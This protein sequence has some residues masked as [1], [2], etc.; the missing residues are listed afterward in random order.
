MP[1]QDRILPPRPPEI[2]RYRALLRTLVDDH[3]EEIADKHGPEAIPADLLELL[4]AL[5]QDPDL[6][7]EP[8]REPDQGDYCFWPDEGD[9][10]WK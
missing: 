2:D 9:Q 8:D 10:R 3:L 7:Q 6:E 4:N 5:D 1:I